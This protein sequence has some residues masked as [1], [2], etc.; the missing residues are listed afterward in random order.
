L[1]TPSQC[2]RIVEKQELQKILAS[3][4][5][6]LLQFLNNLD[7]IPLKDKTEVIK[8]LE[9]VHTDLKSIFR[10]RIPILLSVDDV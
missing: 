1:K 4:L 2:A 5:K 3:I 8:N 6:K 9:D 7:K 10:S